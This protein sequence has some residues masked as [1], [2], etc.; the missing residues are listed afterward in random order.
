MKE[1]DDDS[2]GNHDAYR[3]MRLQFLKVRLALTVNVSHTLNFAPCKKEKA[4]RT[5]LLFTFKLYQH[6]CFAL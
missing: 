2:A 4:S 5:F 3:K 6:C 1:I